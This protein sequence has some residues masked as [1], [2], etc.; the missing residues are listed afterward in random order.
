L[1]P[2]VFGANL[3]AVA[4]AKGGIVQEV[5]RSGRRARPQKH[6]KV[7]PACNTKKPFVHHPDCDAAIAKREA[8][9]STY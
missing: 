6:K 2:G 3:D 4:K 1:E 9:W 7:D 8:V 5:Q